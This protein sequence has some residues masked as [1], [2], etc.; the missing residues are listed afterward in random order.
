MDIFSSQIKFINI[1][2]NVTTRIVLVAKR[3]IKLTLYIALKK[4]DNNPNIA[5]RMTLKRHINVQ[6]N[7]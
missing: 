5:Q 7:Q 2:N 1:V 3:K 4:I 6:R